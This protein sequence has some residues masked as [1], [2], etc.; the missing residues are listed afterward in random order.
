MRIRG[1]VGGEGWVGHA[2]HTSRYKIS[3]SG[4]LY[5]ETVIYTQIPCSYTCALE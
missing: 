2:L 1:G 4:N 3:C 5:S